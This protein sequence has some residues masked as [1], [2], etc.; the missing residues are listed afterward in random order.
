MLTKN[1]VLVKVRVYQYQKFQNTKHQKKK[2]L[3][4]NSVI[5]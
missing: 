4:R 1:I 2:K 3:L 5:S